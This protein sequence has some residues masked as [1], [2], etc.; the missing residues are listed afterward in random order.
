MISIPD[1]LPPIGTPPSVGGA[2]TNIEATVKCYFLD[3]VTKATHSTKD[4]KIL[5]LTSNGERYNKSHD[6]ELI[7]SILIITFK[8]VQNSNSFDDGCMAYVGKPTKIPLF[9]RLRLSN[10]DHDSR[11]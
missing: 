4:S 2:K 6:A 3:L 1:I 7:S 10:H 9:Y 11:G 8:A 5:S